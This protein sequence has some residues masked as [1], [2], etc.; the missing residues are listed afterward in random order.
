M[1]DK[2]G[3]P[4]LPKLLCVIFSLWMLTV[5]PAEAARKKAPPNEELKALRGRINELQKDIAKKEDSKSEVA[6]DLKESEKEISETN[7]TLSELAAEQKETSGELSALQSKTGALKNNVTKHQAD[8]EKVIKNQYQ[9][10]SDDA[11]K[12]LLNGQ[13]PAQVSRHMHYYSYLSKARAESIQGLKT[14]IA[15]LKLAE[16]E[17]RASAKELAELQAEE[18]RQKKKL[19]TERQKRKNLLDKISGQIKTQKREVGKLKQDEARI[20]QLVERLAKMLAQKKKKPRPATTQPA[21]DN[22][23]PGAPVI[24]NDEEPDDSFRGTT[25]ASLRGK[26]KLPVRGELANRYGSPREGGG[27]TWKGLFIRANE[28]AGVKAV[29][30]GKVVFAD[31]LR[32]FG[33]LMI[34]DHGSGYMS[35]YGNNES[36]LKQVGTTIK[37]GD[38]I[39]SVGNSGG[40][41]ESGLYFELR[42][43]GKTLDPLPWTGR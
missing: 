32:G 12:L 16:D 36:L 18:A 7:R 9:S 29:A 2:D 38:T 10:G 4:S 42:H 30:D 27:L 35:L 24:Q 33:N 41:A 28:G 34:L 19:L 25:F 23:K 13:D 3:V 1:S 43:Q 15:Q 40:N 6:D 14:D 8:L 22:V 5:L 39:A 21:P 17:T 11:L 26:L 20:T 31:W 37:P